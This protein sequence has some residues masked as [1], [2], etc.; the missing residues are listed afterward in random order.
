MMPTMAVLLIAVL[1][2]SA[3]PAPT[4]SASEPAMI[5][6]W[7]ADQ[8][9]RWA[10]QHATIARMLDSERSA[11]G[12][13][14]NRDDPNQ[15]AQVGLIQAVL[16]ETARHD[17]NQSAGEALSVYYRIVGL[18]R[19][20]ELLDE[21]DEELSTLIGMADSAAKLN[22]P[23]DDPNELRRR[24]IDVQDQ[25]VQATFGMLALRKRL[26]GLTGQSPAAA[27]VAVLSDS[28]ALEL[29]T[30][31]RDAAVAEAMAERADL[32]AVQTLCRCMNKRSLPAA[33]T[34]LG[35]LQPGLGLSLISASKTCLL[36][37]RNADDGDD[38]GCRRQ[39]CRQLEQSTRHSIREQVLQAELDLQQA[40]ERRRLASTKAT[41]AADAATQQKG[42]V[43]IG[44]AA[45]GSDRLANLISLEADGE[46]VQRAIDVAV[47]EVK[48]RESRGIL[49]K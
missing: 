33:R 17:R 45:I 29:I 12:C 30:L 11:V 15:C 18:Q 35:V 16:R 4:V 5:E 31:D 38:L 44:Q 1:S 42:A 23:V 21:A 25:Q 43:E 46:A 22:L 14:L 41:L 26:A 6:C 39:Q 32:R 49:T 48:F 10:I 8:V 47:A 3:T 7:S 40:L 13:G 37:R 19:Q 34:L 24:R 9:R 2:A 36:G 28:L 20:L 27:S